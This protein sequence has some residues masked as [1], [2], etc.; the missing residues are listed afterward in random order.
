MQTVKF[1][2]WFYTSSLVRKLAE[3]EGFSALPEGLRNTVL[4]RL[5]TDVLCGG[6]QVYRRV[7]A[8]R[9]IR[10]GGLDW[11]SPSM[12][13]NAI[14][15][16]RAMP[17]Y[18]P[19]PFQRAIEQL[20]A[21]T[22]YIAAVEKGYFL[23]SSAFDDSIAII[24]YMGVPVALA[25]S[26]CGI[27]Q[28]DEACALADRTLAVDMGTVAALLS[29]NLTLWM[30]PRMVALNPWMAS[31]PYASAI[32]ATRAIVLIS[33]PA[34]SDTSQIVLQLI[35]R[36]QPNANLDGLGGHALL[37]PNVRAV[38]ALLIATPFSVGFV[39]LS[40]LDGGLLSFASLAS[41]FDPSVLLLPSALTAAA[42]APPQRPN[43]PG[44]EFLFAEST[45]AGCY[46]LTATMALLTRRDFNGTDCEHGGAT[47]EF[48]QWAVAT[49]AMQPEY[50]YHVVLVSSKAPQLS[51]E[52]LFEAS[53][54][55]VSW[56][57]SR[58][59][60]NYLSARLVNFVWAVSMLLTAVL[61]AWLG[62]AAFH[63]RT[64]LRSSQPQFQL[65]IL[66]GV[67]LSIAS[68][69]LATQDH[70]GSLP[71]FSV[72][73]GSRGR[74]PLLD[75]SCVA[76]VWYYF[77]GNALI[78]GAMI[79]KLWRVTKLLVNPAMRDI[80][81]PLHVFLRYVGALVR[82]HVALLTAWT[83]QA[84]PYYRLEIFDRD[85]LHIWHGSCELLPT[86]AMAYPIVL[87]TIELVLIQFGIYLC[88]RSRN[89]NPRYSEGKSI[90]FILWEFVQMTFIGLMVGAL[91]YPFGANGDPVT[92]FLV[93]WLAPM[94]VNIT[95][96]ALM[97]VSKVVEW[98]NKR[99]ELAHLAG[100]ARFF[101]SQKRP[102]S[103]TSGVHPL[104]K[105]GF[106][107]GSCRASGRSKSS[108]RS[109]M[110]PEGRAKVSPA[111][112]QRSERASK[113]GCGT[114]EQQA[115]NSIFGQLQESQ[116]A[117]RLAEEHLLDASTDLTELR[118]RNHD[119]KAEKEDMAQQIVQL[120][121]ALAASAES[122]AREVPDPN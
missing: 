58:I 107:E 26:F 21:S 59:V 37:A 17:E 110:I 112:S 65:I 97:F 13:W 106:H 64:T 90:A 103:S 70:Q 122:G 108:A 115:L 5:K 116:E 51:V 38:S 4:Q 74:Y 91:I 111:V 27:P 61:L 92:F 118:E 62:W 15:Y 68:G 1:W 73:I 18:E 33:T 2:D 98:Y 67:G 72:P 104:H 56:L 10:A 23:S 113:P 29:G 63:W 69:L 100:T 25:F 20:Q 99:K 11:M 88:N 75:R 81:V 109:G 50:L 77:L 96:T 6:I 79:A 41:P 3:Q 71:D 94:S 42:C 36:H 76:Q 31:E 47:I 19:M 102:S 48:I 121:A 87:L 80:R 46:P 44:R 105:V 14:N 85:D 54:D 52:R 93:K 57:E 24:P 45:A 34:E 49:E 9:V 39:P 7:G 120:K 16:E 101:D 89:V 22:L 86:G 8:D 83:V 12:D 43:E 40:G 119:L 30:D 95:V 55:G 84:P 32:G 28:D 35:R 82:L 66:V 60:R 78:F 53:C 117:R 114:H